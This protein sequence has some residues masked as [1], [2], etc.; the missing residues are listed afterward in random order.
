MRN[1]HARHKPLKN[2]NRLSLNTIDG[3][4]YKAP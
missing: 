1:S 2:I 3:G 4:N